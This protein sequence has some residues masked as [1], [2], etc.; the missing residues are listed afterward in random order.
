MTREE[1]AKTFGTPP[2][3][4]KAGVPFQ[5]P[6][7]TT[8]AKPQKS[9]WGQAADIGGA[10][11]KDPINTLITTPTDRATEAITRV[12]APHSLAAEG[13][14]EM[15]DTGEGRDFGLGGF[16]PA[17]KGGVGGVKQIAG[18]ALKDISYLGAPLL[19]KALTPAVKSATILGRAAQGATQ[20]GISG[21]AVGNLHG[22]GAGLQEGEDILP[23][24]ERG[25]KEGLIAGG[26]GAVVGGAVG[27]LGGAMD[28]SALRKQK[29]VDAIKAG[30]DS[31][32]GL[33]TQKVV[34]GELVHDPVG[35]RAVD[36][37]IDK[38]DVALI[39][40]MN[41]KTKEIAAQMRDL[42]LKSI[43]DNGVFAR[44]ED[45]MGKQL[46]DP[47]RKLD[48]L[49]NASISKLDDIAE[50]MKGQ[51][52]D[53]KPAVEQLKSDLIRK[54]VTFSD[55][56]I[57]NFDNSAYDGVTSAQNLI[58]KIVAKV[59]GTHLD[60]YNGHL[61]KKLIDNLV[62][63][64]KTSDGALG[65]AEGIV[66]GF[67]HNLDTAL[68]NTPAFSDYNKVNT[69]FSTIKN[70]I[71]SVGDRLGGD[72]KLNDGVYSDIKAGALVRR[73]FGESGTRGDIL[74]AIADAQKVASQY[75]V[76][77]DVDVLKLGRY[78]QTLR[79]V[80]GTQATGGLTGQVS[81][82]V[83]EG[84]GMVKGGNSLD[85]VLELGE[86]GIKLAR[87][88][89]Q[90]GQSR[91]L[92]E[93]L[94]DTTENTGTITDKTGSVFG[95]AVAHT[96]GHALPEVS[97]HTAVTATEAPTDEAGK[98]IKAVLPNLERGFINPTADIGGK[99]AVDQSGVLGRAIVTSDP[100]VELAK[101]T[102]PD[103][104]N[105]NG[106]IVNG[107][108]ERQVSNIDN[109]LNSLKE[110][111]AGYFEKMGGMPAL[112]KSSQDEIVGALTREGETDTAKY[113]G[114]LNPAQFPTISDFVAFL[115]KSGLA[116]LHRGKGF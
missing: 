1:Y 110:Q 25:L 31:N 54:G 10:I 47:L 24:F 40:S 55:E 15:A 104:A 88:Q 19:G 14:R 111:P 68:D 91:A 5:P 101:Y 103:I 106:K 46:L 84:I 27:A 52:F 89:N 95:K 57:P 81:R 82:G 98:G 96:A 38:G 72:F 8:N 21:F 77:S 102:H 7:T 29:L 50:G 37:G 108:I 23:S 39:K 32:R 66:K 12:V 41:A 97:G 51:D 3:D 33:A 4:V 18:Q 79:D 92:A 78:A 36:T 113:I 69:D 20:A 71:D 43:E 76:A 42:R 22:A 34:D 65:D 112:V 74:Q 30:E 2:P 44:P 115:G 11:I 73:V 9:I 59:D 99:T 90:E 53:Y 56:G 70:A 63:Y 45:A 93:L 116:D 61:T 105:I 94:A 26:T 87:G 86:K 64:G 75:G 109:I 62:D 67:R 28:K 107:V 114:S 85:K 80:Y 60:G 16:V 100:A 13:Y 17:Q 83:K 6:S 58:K 49:K 35:Q 48:E